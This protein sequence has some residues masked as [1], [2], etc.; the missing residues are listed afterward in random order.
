MKLARARITPFRLPLL[1]PLE[2]AQGVFKA[3]LGCLLEIE[4]DSGLIGRGEA[5]PFPGFGMEAFEAVMPALQALV[6]IVGRIDLRD[7]SS[8][9][10]RALSLCP[11]APGARFALD[12]ALHEI[13]AQVEGVSLADYLARGSGSE[14]M[15]DCAV[16]ALVSGSSSEELKV[17]VEKARAQGFS[18]LKLKLGARAW[19]DDLARVRALREAAGPEVRLRLDMGASWSRSEAA[20]R[21]PL[22]AEFG[23]DLIEQPLPAADLAGMVALRVQTR[24]LG[25]HLAADESIVGPADARRVIEHGAADI[26]VLKPAALGGLAAAAELATAGRKAG[27]A[28]VVTSLIDSA[29]GRASALALACALPG[30][31]PAD[32]LAT[33]EWLALDLARS[34]R[35]SNGRLMR[36][37]GVGCGLE[38]DS[39]SLAR[40]RHGPVY[41]V[42]P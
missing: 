16:N 11:E 12:S 17:S 42:C 4:T 10:S 19:E 8:A 38:L 36:A 13:A 1:R 32:G 6:E 18:D 24:S 21:L 31:R 9:R 5:C 30:S 3:R 37:E 39:E 22:L 20:L 40:A 41:E 26:L 2:T 29:W 34:P 23:I 27:L 15:K 28:C 35:P 7:P 33:G 14:A 25:I